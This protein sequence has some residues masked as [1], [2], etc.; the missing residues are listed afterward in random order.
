MLLLILRI[1]VLVN[2]GFRI[3]RVNALRLSFLDILYFFR[4]I[5]G[6]L[7]L[8]KNMIFSESEFSNNQIRELL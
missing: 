4:K 7:A 6:D 1:L 5:I 8:A 3:K 2:F